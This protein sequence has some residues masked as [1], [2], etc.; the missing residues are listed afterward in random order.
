MSDFEFPV[1]QINDDEF[2]YIILASF[3]RTVAGYDFDANE[4]AP[5]DS[6]MLDESP[7]DE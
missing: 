7:L 1:L 2:E 5:L 3:T 6:Q 4:E